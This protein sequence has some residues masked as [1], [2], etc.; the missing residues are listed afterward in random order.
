MH[1][2]LAFGSIK[3]GKNR[4]LTQVAL[5]MMPVAVEGKS[6]GGAPSCGHEGKA[7]RIAKMLDKA[8]PR[9]AVC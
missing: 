3:G 6:G 7:K 5:V 4:F 1:K 2:Y 8:L 9:T